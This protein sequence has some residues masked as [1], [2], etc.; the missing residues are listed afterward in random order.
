[1]T[2]LSAPSP[3]ARPRPHDRVSP[4]R[5]GAR[6]RSGRPPLR[7]TRRGRAVLLAAVTLALAAGSWVL[8]RH[9]SVAADGRQRPGVLREVTVLPGETLWAIAGRVCPHADPRDVVQ[10]LMD[11]NGV[12]PALSPGDVL[13][14]PADC[15]AG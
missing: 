8:L 10:R 15:Y 12:G 11:V 14:V 6:R 2:A 1:M 7:L 3:W 5:A 13:A 4:A 9:P